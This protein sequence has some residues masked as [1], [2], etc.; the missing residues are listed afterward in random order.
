MAI[1]RKQSIEERR[2][3]ISGQQRIRG[4]SGQ[5]KIYRFIKPSREWVLDLPMLQTG[6]SGFFPRQR[7][8]EDV[9][10]DPETGGI[11]TSK[12][13]DLEVKTDPATGIIYVATNTPE[14]LTFMQQRPLPQ[15]QESIDKL[16]DPQDPEDLDR[17]RKAKLYVTMEVWDGIETAIRQ[18]YHILEESDPKNLK[19]EP[20][21][22]REMIIYMDRLSHQYREGAVTKTRLPHV[23]RDVAERVNEAN[24]SNAINPDKQRLAELAMK[25]PELFGGYI[26]PQASRQI[27]GGA[28]HAARRRMLTSELIQR[29]FGANLSVLLA[30]RLDTRT[31]MDTAFERL[32]EAERILQ[33]ESVSEEE[34]RWI[35]TELQSIAAQNLRY[36]RVAPYL[37]PSRLAAIL[38]VGCRDEKKDLNRRVLGDETAEAIY[39]MAPATM[40]LGNGPIADEYEEVDGRNE[41]AIRRIRWARMILDEALT[42]GTIEDK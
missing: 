16:E 10:Y 22:M 30:E 3:Q 32:V 28:I 6:D 36:P 38:L 13:D 21:R 17:K 1:E 4:L 29:K 9:R 26:N 23:K 42:A 8:Q 35:A 12:W 15:D 18:Q 34:R 27:L 41:E 7:F 2:D 5:E 14:R 11:Y 39:R 24:L 37:I 33:A 40:L 19:G 20:V 25:A 31:N